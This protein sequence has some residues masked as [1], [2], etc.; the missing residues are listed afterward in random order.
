VE[1]ALHLMEALLDGPVGATALA[2]KL[3]V[4]KATAFRLARTLQANGYVVQLDD[5]R[6]AL[7]PRCLILS[8][9]AY[10][11]IDIRR[12]LRW[13]EEELSER[14]GETILLSV[15]SGRDA[16]CIDSIPSKQNV[17]SLAS[18]GEIWPLHTSSAGMVF[19]ANDSRL[20]ESY[21]EKGD[22]AAP[23]QNTV[24][25]P[26]GIRKLVR[27]AQEKGYAVNR[28]YWRE[29]VA[30]FAALVHDASGRAA[31]ALG[32]IMPEFRLDALGAETV[33][34]L[35][36]DVANRASA[37]LGFRGKADKPRR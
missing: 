5:T 15:L 29:D 1:R 8:A 19:M 37:R 14:T 27:E 3:E 35:I 13:A 26:E 28:S 9:W 12:E 17:V 24:T 33:G 4:S 7:G 6:D 30:G 32:M 25:D 34:E 20:L 18:V 23:T 21:L 2:A 31:A 10:D 22:L 16:V 36:L 11:H